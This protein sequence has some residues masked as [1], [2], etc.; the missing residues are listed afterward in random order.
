MSL[1][2]IAIYLLAIFS[3]V[4]PLVMQSTAR[5]CSGNCSTDGCS[6]ERSAAQTCC[7]W[8]KKQLVSRLPQQKYNANCCATKQSKAA[9]IPTP[10]GSCC[11]PRNSD[12]SK[13]PIESASTSSTA[14]QETRTTTISTGTCGNSRLF[15]TGAPDSTQH[16]PYFFVEASPSPRQSTLT[17]IPP[18]RL[19]SL[20]G[21]PPEPPPKLV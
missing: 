17:S 6:L 19:T 8:Q 5:D 10:V 7:C 18:N 9:P 3:P 11:P 15:A 16:L 4:A 2:L 20:H 13:E 14:P 12:T 1:L 21:K